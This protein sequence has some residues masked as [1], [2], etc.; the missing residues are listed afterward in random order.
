[1]ER[2]I[3]CEFFVQIRHFL[4]QEFPSGHKVTLTGPYRCATSNCPG[5]FFSPELWCM[6]SCG[7]ICAK[8]GC[9]SHI[10]PNELFPDG[11]PSAES[12]WHQ[13]GSTV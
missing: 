6:S 12:D 1:M 2:N 10:V 5:F 9:E 8:E 4:A 3:S 13:V 7:V 11:M